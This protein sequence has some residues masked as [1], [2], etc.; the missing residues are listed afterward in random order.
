[1]G[2]GKTIQVI[3]LICHLLQK[4][5]P[6]PY[7][8]AV[9]LSTLPNWL[10]EF[11]RFA[12]QVPVVKF[13]GSAVDRKLIYP[14]LKKTYKIGNLLTQPVIV[15]SYQVPRF[16]QKFLLNFKFQYIIVDEGHAI[17]NH[18]SQISK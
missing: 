13:H 3:A 16:E 15:T 14:L 7:L 18:E 4:D 1:M 6:G 10:S 2:L 11:K 9:P 12:P 17:K 8:I 5:V